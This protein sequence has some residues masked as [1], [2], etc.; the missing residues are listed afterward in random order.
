MFTDGSDDGNIKD[1]ALNQHFGSSVNLSIKTWSVDKSG[2][3]QEPII[4]PFALPANYDDNPTIKIHFFTVDLGV[5][6]SKV[7][8]RVRHT[9]RGNNVSSTTTASLTTNTGSDVTVADAGN[10]SII[11]YSTTVTL[12][13]SGYDAGDW[14]VLYYDRVAPA[15]SQYNSKVYL[16]V[17]EF[18]YDCAN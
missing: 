15:N 2:Q 4:L 11:H 3:S 12:T 1:D 6:G 13:D 10:N 9:T 17:V 8:W 16:S 5:G 7:K 18:G 14:I